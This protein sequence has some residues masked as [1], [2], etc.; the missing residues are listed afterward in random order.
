M[1]AMP[2]RGEL[3]NAIFQIRGTMGGISYTKAGIAG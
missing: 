1:H 2:E 3:V